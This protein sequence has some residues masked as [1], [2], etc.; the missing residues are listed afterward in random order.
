LKFN[1][2][3]VTT[4]LSSVERWWAL[5]VTTAYLPEA[6]SPNLSIISSDVVDF[7]KS[8]EVAEFPM[9]LRV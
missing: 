8:P 3:L 2:Y 7:E 5:P 6:A 9:V 1:I 4:E